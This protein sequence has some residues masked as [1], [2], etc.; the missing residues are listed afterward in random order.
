ML[1]PGPESNPLKKAPT[2]FH[3]RINNLI[4]EYDRI[5]IKWGDRD[6]GQLMLDSSLVEKT[7]AIILAD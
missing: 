1:S 6:S 2:E 5:L 3:K 4:K 7:T